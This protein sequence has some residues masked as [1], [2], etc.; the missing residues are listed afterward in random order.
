MATAHVVGAGVAGL[1]A[2][3]A[4][5]ESGWRVTVWEMARQAGGRCRSYDDARLG[6]RIDNGNHLVLSGNR[7]T[8]AYL[9][10][11]GA[12]HALRM[13][14]EARFPFVDL[15][16]GERWEVHIN[17]GP[18]PWWPIVPS[19]RPAGVG[20]GAFVAAL[21]LLWAGEHATIAEAV[22]PRGPALA[23]FWEPMSLAVMNLPPALASARLMRATVIEAWRDG[24]L[25]RP[26]FAP[27]GL[28][29]ALVEP[30]LAALRRAGADVRFGA[31]VKALR[32]EGG[33]VAGLHVAGEAVPLGP[34]DAVVLAVP[35][36]RVNA[37]WP[38]ARAPEEASS[39]LNAHFR[40]A[41]PVAGPPLLG[42]TGA[43][44]QWIF[45][46]DELISL[47][48]SA[49]GFVEGTDA[50]E[51]ALLDALWAETRAALGLPENLRPLAARLV[52]ER[53]ATFLQTPANAARRAQAL[54]ALPN[55]VLA[56]DHIDTGLP[57][58]IEGAARSGETAARLLGTP[59]RSNGAAPRAA[60]GS[61]R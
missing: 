49:A 7:S 19:R 35:P 13:A 53:R 34:D 17:D 24:R 29:A 58:T 12:P 47:T 20:L 59:A 43:R 38:D 40:L 50:E 33:R 11:A 1:S 22:R 2:A 61:G 3:L 9:A 25:C 36:Q 16:S 32:V 46:K 41:A 30:A 57:A 27:H 5:A 52:H 28:G 51:E 44:T 56:G 60:S 6:C 10:R 45:L 54:T 42:V 37:L 4:L 15:A 18:L 31:Q 26:M 55:L 39:I 8:L 48:I 14:P 23:R 21:P